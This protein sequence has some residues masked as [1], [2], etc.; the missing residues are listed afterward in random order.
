[1]GVNTNL[2]EVI[3]MPWS[4]TYFFLC[5]HCHYMDEIPAHSLPVHD[6]CPKCGAIGFRRQVLEDDQLVDFNP[7]KHV[8]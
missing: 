7:K 8:K 5:R 3:K 1:M 2:K 4:L 6:G